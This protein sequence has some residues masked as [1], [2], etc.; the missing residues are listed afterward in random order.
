M[1]RLL[2]FLAL[3]AFGL[4]AANARTPKR[5]PPSLVDVKIV[6]R[7]TGQSLETWRHEGKFYVV[8]VPGNRYAISLTNR[9]GKRV[10]TVLSVDGV[11]ALSGQTA[12]T[13]QRGYVLRAGQHYEIAGWRK[14]ASEVAA[15]YFTRLSDSYAARTDRPDNVGVIGVAV[16]REYEPPPPVPYDVETSRAPG[17]RSGVRKAAKAAPAATE[18]IGT[19]HGERI[20][21]HTRTVDF[22]RA[23]TSPTQ[24]IS[25][26]YDTYDN[27][28]VRGVIPKHQPHRPR[29]PQAFPGEGYVPDPK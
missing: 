8:G 27:L 21:S 14:S 12:R 15:F 1:K 28:V 19:G 22:R 9:T 20:E 26:Y 3:L 24:V 5:L 25:I 2:T 23:S 7:T 17:G 6:D 13:S 18:S 16:Y 10:L 29:P 11:N 4:C